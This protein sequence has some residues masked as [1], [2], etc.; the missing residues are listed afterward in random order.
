LLVEIRASK[1]I[2]WAFDPVAAIREDRE[3]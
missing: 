2:Q 1:P 3:R